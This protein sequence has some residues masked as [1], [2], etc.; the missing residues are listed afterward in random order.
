MIMLDK[1][2]GDTLDSVDLV[3]EKYAGADKIATLDWAMMRLCQCA[4]I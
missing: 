3:Q 1:A 2:I 4:A